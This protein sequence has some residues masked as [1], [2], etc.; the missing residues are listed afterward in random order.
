MRDVL[1][2]VHD[3]FLTAQVAVHMPSSGVR[4]FAFRPG[5]GHEIPLT[6][7]SFADDAAF[8]VIRPTTPQVWKR[9]RCRRAIVE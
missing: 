2:E 8:F 5:Y 7:I 9:G 4:S 1:A 3:G 6:G